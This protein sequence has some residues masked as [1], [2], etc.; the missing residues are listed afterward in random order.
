MEDYSKDYLEA[1]APAATPQPSP[2]FAA[3]LALGT[4]ARRRG[5][6]AILPA[7]D[8][9]VPIASRFILTEGIMHGM[10]VDVAMPSG[11]VWHYRHSLPES[12]G[13]VLLCHIDTTVPLTCGL[14]QP[15]SEG[16]HPF[17]GSALRFGVDRS[18]A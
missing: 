17:L 9:A 10:F 11:A 8:H 6:E 15:T 4:E 7:S 16:I 3:A 1:A 2:L 12:D 13:R 14:F 5:A 18:V